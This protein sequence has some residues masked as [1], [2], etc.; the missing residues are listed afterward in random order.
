MFRMIVIG[1]FSFIGISLFAL[2]GLATWK[3]QDNYR[4]GFVGTIELYKSSPFEAQR[5]TKQA[6]Q[7]CLEDQAGGKLPAYYVDIMTDSIAA[8]FR[9]ASEN[10][11]DS[12]QDP[13]A[14]EFV[15]E[16]K[17]TMSARI[18]E[19]A[20]RMEREPESVQRRLNK[21]M[22]WATTSGKSAASCVALNV[23]RLAAAEQ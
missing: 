12:S 2:Q 6:T 21:S 7:T 15:S 18:D 20:R 14:Q 22:D 11:F 9:F 13:V 16:I 5:L 19:I 10:D 1:F 23:V 8:T 3:K 4:K 17:Q